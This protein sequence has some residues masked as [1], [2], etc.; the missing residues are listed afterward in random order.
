VLRCL[1]PLLAVLSCLLACAA[2]SAAEQPELSV[3]LRTATDGVAPGGTLRVALVCTLSA[4]WHM[5]AHKPLDEFLIPTELQ[6]KAEE[7]IPLNP[8]S[9]GD[10]RSAP[11]IVKSVG[12]PEAK[13]VT[14]SFSP[15]ALA[16][17][18]G[19]FILGV[20]IAVAADAA[21]GT[22]ALHGTLRYQ[23]CN[24]KSCMPP[25]D[26]PVELPVKILAQGVAP[27]PLEGFPE[28][29]W[30]EVVKFD[31]PVSAPPGQSPSKQRS[32]AWLQPRSN[33]AVLPCGH[34]SIDSVA[35]SALL[36]R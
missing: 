28:A 1:G 26:K 14:L 30:S 7:N 3:E 34:S 31:V 12:Y 32:G 22:Q 36:A 2:L 21:P 8:P 13:Q 5:N 15:T 29:T 9:K 35:E 10:L 24:D 4:G 23:A 17:Y 20:E 33:S 27:P 6:F 19:R 25:V 18:E 16:V 11:L